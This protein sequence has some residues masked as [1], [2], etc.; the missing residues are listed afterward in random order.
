MDKI[1]AQTA[2]SGLVIGGPGDGQFTSAQ[3]R[4]MILPKTPESHYSS[5][6]SDWQEYDFHRIGDQ[7]F[8][9]PKGVGCCWLSRTNYVMQNLVAGYKGAIK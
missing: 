6:K 8:W 7:G 4:E 2:N 5:L 1:D 9:I 3:L